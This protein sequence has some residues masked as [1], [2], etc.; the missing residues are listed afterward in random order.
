MYVCK[1]V[2]YGKGRVCIENVCNEDAE[3]EF[4]PHGQW[5]EAG[6]C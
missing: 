3:K 4:V 5:Q 6:K 2:C 1:S